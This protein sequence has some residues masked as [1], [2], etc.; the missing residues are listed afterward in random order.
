MSET[1]KLQNLDM[2]SQ[3]VRSVVV[4][5][6]IRLVNVNIRTEVSKLNGDDCRALIKAE[7]FGGILKRGRM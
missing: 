1:S 2:V 6:K 5:V 3:M 7:L 4:C